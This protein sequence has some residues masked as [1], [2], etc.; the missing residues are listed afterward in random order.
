MTERGKWLWMIAGALLLAIVAVI[1]VIWLN[2]PGLTVPFDVAPEDL[3]SE[4]S[5]SSSA[6]SAESF[7][8]VESEVGDWFTV[9]ALTRL[10]DHFCRV[11]PLLCAVYNDG[12]AVRITYRL[13]TTKPD[14]A[15]FVTKDSADG[16]V[17]ISLNPSY[18]PQYEDDFSLLSRELARALFDV[19]DAAYGAPATESGGAW[20]VDGLCEY[21]LF[22]CESESYELP[23]FLAGQTY[24]DSASAALRFFIWITE[25]YEATFIEQMIEALRCDPYTPKLFVKI[26]GYTLDELWNIYTVSDHGGL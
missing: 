8:I 4:N 3:L 17:V 19:R 14:L 1:V 7:L 23:S 10:R 13:D 15:A 5:D 2:V 20:V 11:Y 21:G 18:F 16:T 6:K 12:V 25:R 22:L 24:T 26:T 9:P